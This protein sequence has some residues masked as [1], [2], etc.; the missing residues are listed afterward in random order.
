M[1]PVRFEEQ[2]K[3]QLQKREI[4]PSAGSWEKLE[5]RLE[6]G[7]KPPK[8]ILWWVGIAAAIAG[9]FFFLGT[10]FDPGVEPTIVEQPSEEI[11][12][13]EPVV[14]QKD[15]VLIASE[16]TEEEEVSKPVPLPEKGKSSK[17]EVAV[18]VQGK[19]VEDPISESAEPEIIQ[20]QEVGEVVAEVKLTPVSDEEIDAL[21]NAA[22]AN[23]EQ[24]RSSYAVQ[25]VDAEELLQEVEY[26]LDQ[27]FR[28]K[29]FEVLKEG[30]S[31][32]KTAVANRN[33]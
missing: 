3:E 7:G 1:E 30:F 33:F 16:E 11:K 17:T 29:V 19:P 20:D 23:L 8:P 32:A 10:L 18:A 5:T 9:V 2:I 14:I 6:Q 25:P 24:E 31:K 15:E 22:M 21:L 13:Q 12:I 28:Q 27:S 26:E 4:K